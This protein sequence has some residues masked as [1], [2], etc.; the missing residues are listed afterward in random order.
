MADEPAPTGDE[1]VDPPD[2]TPAPETEPEQPKDDKL[3]PEIQEILT[4]ER[5]AARDALRDAKTAKSALAN[6]TSE[7]EKFREAQLTEQEK[8]I[9]TAREEALAE[10]LKVGNQRLIRAEIIAAAAGKV[11]DPDDAYAILTA[12]GALEGLEVDEAGK[13]DTQTI[14]TA[15]DDLVKAKPHLAAVRSPSFGTRSP[16]QAPTTDADMDAL[17]RGARG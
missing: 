5:K 15:I 10:G 8:A 9:K 11:A 6:A 2:A 7:L 16:A 12:S 17:I 14:V 3:P 13:V 1:P 4:K